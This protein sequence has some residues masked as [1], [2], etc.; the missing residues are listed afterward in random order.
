MIPHHEIGF[1]WHLVYTRNPTTKQWNG[2]ANDYMQ[3]TSNVEIRGSSSVYEPDYSCCCYGRGAT[4]ISLPTAF[5]TTQV[6]GTPPLHNMGLKK[7]L[8][9]H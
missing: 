5:G 8:W 3:H 4:P 2:L 6:A 9:R 7:Q 1:E